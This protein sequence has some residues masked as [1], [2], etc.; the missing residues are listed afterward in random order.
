MYPFKQHITDFDLDGFFYMSPR[1]EI[2]KFTSWTLNEGLNEMWNLS[3]IEWSRSVQTTIH[4]EHP[5][6]SFLNHSF[7]PSV[8]ISRGG[9][10]YLD[11]NYLDRLDD[12]LDLN[13]QEVTFNY[14]TTESDISHPFEDRDTGRYVGT[15]Q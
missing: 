4:V 5:V 3:Y 15:N 14:L 13:H 1:G 10:I 7:D 12:I 9:I 2:L 8:M 11:L 6:G